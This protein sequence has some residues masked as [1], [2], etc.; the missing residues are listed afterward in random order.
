M[1]NR[2][3]VGALL[4]TM[5][6]SS[7]AR[8]WNDFGHMAVAAVAFKKLKPKAKTRA[9]QLLKLNPRYANWIVGA[10]KSDEPRIAFMRAATWAD[11]IKSDRAYKDDG[12]PGAGQGPGYLDLLRHPTWHYVN[13]P[14]SRDGT[15]LVDGAVP[16]VASQITALRTELCAAATSDEQKSYDLA[17][18][19]HLVGDVHQPLH[20]VARFDRATASGDRGGNLVKI[21]GNA[22]PPVC[23]DP[24][25]CPF[26]PPEDLHAF[27]DAIVGAGYYTGEVE[28]AANALP[29]AKSEKAAIS[30]VDAWVQ[31]GFELA[32][33]A[34]YVSPINAGAG[35]FTIDAAYQSAALKLGRERMSLAGAR[36]AALVNEC[37]GK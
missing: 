15:P 35:P 9:A 20:C 14:F 28:T 24:R 21:A 27:Y 5:S 26:G 19:L 22:Q 3:A 33:T 2:W 23:D 11:A 1:R 8:A 17:W 31:E 4:A 16:N 34:V 32:Q 30:D 7:A 36:L 37:L 18:L 12:S 29:A 13:R 10:R 6:V 25:Y